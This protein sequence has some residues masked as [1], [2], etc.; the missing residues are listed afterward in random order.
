MPFKLLPRI[1]HSALRR[2]K[3]ESDDVQNR[4][5]RLVVDAHLKDEFTQYGF[6]RAAHIIITRSSSS[7][8][9]VVY[10]VK[11]TRRDNDNYYD[12]LPESMVVLTRTQLDDLL[13][14]MVFR[15]KSITLS[16][17]RRSSIIPTVTR[18]A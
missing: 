1:V 8:R 4:W 6:P 11:V 12:A 9:R 7:P 2:L 15:A 18:L 16:H 10:H 3:M 17:R 13:Y 5:A 14:T